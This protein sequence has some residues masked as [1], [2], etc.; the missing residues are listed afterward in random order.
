[1]SALRAASYSRVSSSHQEQ[2][3]SSLGTQAAAIN[4]FI[5]QRGYTLDP[6]QVYQDV[7]T[8]ADLRERPGM[9]RL[10]EVIRAGGVDVVV[11]YALDRLT[12]NQAHLG[13]LV[14]EAE[15]HN[16]RLECVT[17]Q[18]DETPV[19]VLVRNVRAYAA[20]M[21]REKI[22]ERTQR[23]RSARL[24]SGKMLPGQ[25]PVYGYQWAD[26]DKTTIVERSDT[27]AVVRRIFHLASTGTPARSIA[28]M[29]TEEGLP[30]PGGKSHWSVTTITNMLRCEVYVGI[31]HGWR[32]KHEV[33]LVRDS[34]GTMRKQHHYTPHPVEEHVVIQV[35]ALVTKEEAQAAQG[36]LAVNRNLAVR[37]NKNPERALLRSGYAVCGYCGCSMSAASYGPDKEK[38]KYVCNPMNRDKF[39]CPNFMQDATILDNDVWAAITERLKNP[40]LIALEVEALR[41][42]DPTTVDLDVVETRLASIKKQQANLVKHLA[43]VGDDDVAALFQIELSALSKQATGVMAELEAIRAE[44]EGW[45]LAQERLNDMTIWCQRVSENL[46]SF[47]YEQKRNV[48]NALEIEVRVWQKTHEPRWEIKANLPIVSTTTRRRHSRARSSAPR[49]WSGCTPAWRR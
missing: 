21:E 18:W 32:G 24:A 33:V 44:R 2:E 22:R 17:E 45:E 43:T 12:R 8:G 14:D 37:N 26:T 4:A 41:K 48:L 5:D 6:D 19:G 49:S 39:G 40:E 35:P 3:G 31:Y 9:S 10:R 25:R 11:F 29:L 15:S 7:H 27:A 20:E 16:V 1:M 36:R 38:T 46:E 30:T 23:G 28:R 34:H 13:V 42:A 47:T